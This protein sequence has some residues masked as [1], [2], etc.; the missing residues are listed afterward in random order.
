[1]HPSHLTLTDKAILNLPFTA[2]GQR[3]V[4]DAE[5]SG[6]FVV[7]GKRTKT[8]MVQ[9][10]LRA[11]GKRQSVRLKVGEAGELN[12]REARAKAKTLLGSIAKGIDPRAKQATDHASIHN[13]GAMAK[14][15]AR[16][17]PTCPLPGPGIAKRISSGRDGVKG[18]LRIFATM[19]ND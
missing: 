17:V 2:A 1:M 7:V 3:L 4:R 18:Q 16:R 13:D 15:R 9:G 11:N 12:T 19:S 14:I 8:F 10:D 5:L 6:F